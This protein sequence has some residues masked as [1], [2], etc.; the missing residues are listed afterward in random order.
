MEPELNIDALRKQ[1]MSQL[2]VLSQ[3]LSALSPVQ[4]ITADNFD[5]YDCGAIPAP[6]ASGADAQKIAAEMRALGAEINELNLEIQARA[7]VWNRYV[8]LRD[9]AEKNAAVE[10]GVRG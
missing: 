4:H 9:N 10:E 2:A 7:R 8:E 5:T 3:R 6:M 1:K